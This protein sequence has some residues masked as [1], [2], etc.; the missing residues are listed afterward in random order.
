MDTKTEWVL[1]LGRDPKPVTPDRVL[2]FLQDLQAA[3]Q[4]DTRVRT[5]YVA[6][7]HFLSWDQVEATRQAGYFRRYGDRTEWTGPDT[8]TLDHAKLVIER[9]RTLRQE[10]RY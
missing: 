9:T 3:M 10:R 1:Y 7:S 5:V 8:L 6:M 4:A 2:A